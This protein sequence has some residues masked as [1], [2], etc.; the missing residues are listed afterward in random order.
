MLKFF[1]RPR[2]YLF[3]VAICLSCCAINGCIE[4]IW[5]L[6]S[7]SRLPK[8]ITLPPGLTRADV[9]V[10]EEAME[11]T[12]RGV[13]TKVVLYNKKY[14]KL[15]EVSGNS[16]YLSRRYFIDVVN[17]VPEIIGLTHHNNE[18]GVDNSYFFV[19]DDPALKRKLLDENEWKLLLDYG[20]DY[21]AVREKLLDEHGGPSCAITGCGQPSFNLASESRL[22]QCIT[23]PPGLSRKDVS[24][25]LY[26]RSAQRGL[27]AKFI[28]KNQE[29]EK[30]VEVRGRVDRLAL[31]NF[32]FVSD[33]GIV[34]VVKLRPYR[35]HENMEQNGR[36]VALFYVLDNSVEK[37]ML[38][39]DSD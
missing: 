32:K 26:L 5:E 8:G 33:N 29:G 3:I 20:I 6:T 37:R 12:R 27:D 11:P 36:A 34:D 31:M 17:G 15:A 23:L 21:P 25:S 35:E 18:H 9:I 28:L 4:S 13:D 38:L 7:D 22:P 24:V 16:F 39:G 2:K 14:K 19:V 1:L 30:L 10:V